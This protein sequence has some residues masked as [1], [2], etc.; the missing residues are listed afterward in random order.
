MS[1]RKHHSD[2]DI[3]TLLDEARLFITEKQ[4]GHSLVSQLVDRIESFENII[5]HTRCLLETGHVK[6]AL[7][8][9]KEGK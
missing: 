7:E 2:R 8:M 1:A 3:V 4:V 6:E 9:L 5:G